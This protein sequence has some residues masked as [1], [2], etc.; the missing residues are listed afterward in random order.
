MD[1]PLSYVYV[2][3]VEED[4]NIYVKGLRRETKDKQTFLF[5][6]DHQELAK[7]PAVEAQL[8]GQVFQHYRNIKIVSTALAN[9][10]DAV[11]DMFIFNG[12]ALKEDLERS[13]SFDEEGRKTALK[14]L[15]F[16]K[17]LYLIFVVTFFAEKKAKERVSSHQHLELLWAVSLKARFKKLEPLILT[18]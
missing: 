8:R 18:I 3:V 1:K 13:I 9:Y 5:E 15:S 17:S 14:E 11:R 12:K 7:H 4:S 16:E 2:H 10:Y 6:S